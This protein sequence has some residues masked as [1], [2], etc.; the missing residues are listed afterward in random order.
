MFS[1]THRPVRTQHAAQFGKPDRRHL[2]RCPRGY[3]PRHIT[4]STR[5]Y[6]HVRNQSEDICGSALYT[7]GT[8]CT[9]AINTTAGSKADGIRSEQLSSHALDDMLHI[10]PPNQTRLHSIKDRRKNSTIITA[11]LSWTHTTHQP[12]T[13]QHVFTTDLCYVKHSQANISIDGL[14]LTHQGLS[15]LVVLSTVWGLP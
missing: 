1:K 13:R 15:R 8:H 10:T 3:H 14:A 5:Q 11:L 6:I 12:S 9:P 7:E 4:H 2:R